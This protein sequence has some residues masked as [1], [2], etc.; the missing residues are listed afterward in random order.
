MSIFKRLLSKRSAAQ[1]N[2]VEIPH[3]SVRFM[4]DESIP[5]HWHHRRPHITRFFDGLSLMF[6]VGEKVFIES[7][8]HYR[9]LIQRNPTLLKAVDGFVYQEATHIRE[10]RAYNLWLKAQGAPVEQLES[11]LQRR[12]ERNDWLPAPIRLALTACLEHLTSIISDQVLRNPGVLAGADPVM[13][14][15]WRWHAIEETEHKAVAFDVMCVVET[16]RL[17]G[18]LRRC[19]L[20]FI[21]AASFLFDLTHFT[22]IL[23]RSDRQHHNWREW[24]RLQWW[25]FVNPGLLTRIVPAALLWFVPGFHPD[26]LDSRD[27]LEDARRAFDE[28]IV[29]AAQ[30]EH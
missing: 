3:R 6:P 28:S 20:M 9:P 27:V 13:A 30:A 5:R 4:L 25:L 26:R 2:A 22:Y 14:R 12:I 15:L 16:N 11:L 21:V 24:L 29:P 1:I 7:V 17:R 23:V 8:M 10:H 19:A 18:Y